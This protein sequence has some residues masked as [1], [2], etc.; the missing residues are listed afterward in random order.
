MTEAQRTQAIAWRK[1][2]DSF[3]GKIVDSPAEI[4]ENPA[5]IR[6]WEPGPFSAGDESEGTPPD[7]RM[8]DG[9]PY[10][11]N[12]DHDS[13]DNPGWNPKDNPA[14]WSQYHGTSKETARP[15]IHPT[16]AHDIYKEGEYAIFDDGIIKRATMDTSFSPDEYTQAWEDVE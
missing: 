8:Y 13:T 11:C 15:F 10:K 5:A 12:Q 2:L 9:D 3:V 7:V 14:L 6:T 1:A 16:G 4:N